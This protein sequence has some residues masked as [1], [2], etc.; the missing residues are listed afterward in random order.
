[1]I[2]FCKAGPSVFSRQV[3][4]PLPWQ[5]QMTQY[6]PLTNRTIFYLITNIRLT[7]IKSFGVKHFDHFSDLR[8]LQMEF[9]TYYLITA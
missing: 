9:V 1:M 2:N 8:Q 6:S 5:L 4:T 7:L 3:L